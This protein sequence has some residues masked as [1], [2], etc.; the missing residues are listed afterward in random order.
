MSVPL[1][2]DLGLRALARARRA[3]QDN[4]HFRFAP[5]SL[6]FLMSPSYWCASRWLCTCATVSIVTLTTI[7]SDVPPK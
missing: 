1:F 4:V 7:S 6:D 3:D 2:E 5:L